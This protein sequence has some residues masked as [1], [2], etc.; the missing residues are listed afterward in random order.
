MATHDLQR[1]FGAMALAAA[2]LVS[3]AAA[4]RAVRAE[5]D[6]AAGEA[7]FKRSCAFCH[8]LDPAAKKQGPHLD[9]LI[10]RPAGS[11][12]GFNY[13]PALAQSGIVWSAETLDAYLAAP[14]RRVPGTRMSVGVPSEK[15]RA[16][17]IA[18]LMSIGH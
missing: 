15:N 9:G 10:D 18:Y 11:V 12:A 13:S 2:V 8:S 3:A 4:A 5:G 16:D 14:T 1:R 17:L 7:V 6:A